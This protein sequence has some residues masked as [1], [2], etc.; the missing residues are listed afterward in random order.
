MGQFNG[1]KLKK[2]SKDPDSWIS[3]LELLRTR[4][5]KMVTDIGDSYMMMYVLNNVPSAY[6]NVVK[7]LEDTLEATTDPLRIELS[8]AVYNNRIPY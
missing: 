5:K 6:D 2:L 3:E 8:G 4:L 7:T 1:L